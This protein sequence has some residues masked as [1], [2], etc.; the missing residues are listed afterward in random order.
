[1]SR[2]VSPEPQSLA[3]DHPG[4]AHAAGRLRRALWVWAGLFAGMG[5]L[6]FTTEGRTHPVVPL[7][8]L[9]M[10]I[11]LVTDRQPAFL[12]LVA[13]QWGLSLI[14][15]VPGF[16]AVFGGDPVTIS[17]GGT[18]PEI[19]GLT[20]VRVILMITAWNQFMFYRMLY[21]TA[22]ASGLDPS[23]P[24]VPEVVPNRSDTLAWLSR[25]AGFLGVCLVLTGLALRATV[26]VIPLVSTAFVLSTLAIGL[27]LGAAF[28]PTQRRGHALAGVALGLFASLSGLAVGAFVGSGRGL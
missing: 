18:L 15:V 16:A 25:L 7:S 13:A 26:A 3:T 19:I 12:A 4:L 21:G 8:W 2:W 20:V 28:S 17:I 1:M 5:V 9:V 11:V 24:A 27:G 14:V 23:L 6:A 10:A 22:Q